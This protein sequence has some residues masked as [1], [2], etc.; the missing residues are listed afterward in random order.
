MTIF[1]KEA[2]L[3]K[4]GAFEKRGGRPADAAAKEAAKLNDII[5]KYI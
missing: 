3:N 5:R 1:M 4:A 2:F